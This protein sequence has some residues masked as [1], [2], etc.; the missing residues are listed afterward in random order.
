MLIA[1][2][3]ISNPDK[4][5]VCET[6]VRSGYTCEEFKSPDEFMA[7]M[8]AVI[9]DLL[10]VKCDAVDAKVMAFI[11]T[12]RSTV[13]PFLPILVSS[14][15][16]S[17]TD[18]EASLRAGANECTAFG[19][20]KDVL[21]RSIATWLRWAQ[22]N[23]TREKQFRVGGYQVCVSRRSI[24]VRDR[25]IQLTEKQFDVAMALLTNIGR[26]LSRDHICNLVWGVQLNSF[27]RRIDTHISALRSELLLDGKNGLQL[28]TIYGVGYRLMMV[29]HS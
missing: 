1:I 7:R 18:I 5:A 9:F 17:Q 16:G 23:T 2:V 3:E 19:T 22:Y 21:L 29:D 15:E 28:L 8:Q 6:L 25:T 11:Q 27:S 14:R 12:L 26:I 20:S 4:R 13:G 24:Q 10:I